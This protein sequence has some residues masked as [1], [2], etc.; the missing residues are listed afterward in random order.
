MSAASDK[1]TVRVA[2]RYSC[3]KFF[4]VLCSGGGLSGSIEAFETDD[5]ENRD[6]SEGREKGGP[7]I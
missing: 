6:R 4:I 7:A 5:G 2:R 3:A 1:A